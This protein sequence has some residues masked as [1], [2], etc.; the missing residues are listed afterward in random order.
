[1]KNVLA[2]SISLLLPAVPVLADT[3]SATTLANQTAQALGDQRE[4]P[5]MGA[6]P[7]SA[8]T[9]APPVTNTSAPSAG[10]KLDSGKVG[11]LQKE[12]EKKQSFFAKM[13]ANLM[14]FVKK[15][16]VLAGA[17]LGGM[18]CAFGG[19]AVFVIGVSLGAVAGD[20]VSYGFA[21]FKKPKPAD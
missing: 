17:I 13:K 16:P 20:L 8:P 10:S 4:A 9:G 12:T 21:K 11:A 19:P 5:A 6:A 14:G 2:L 18:L 7:T 15:H 3:Q 1:M